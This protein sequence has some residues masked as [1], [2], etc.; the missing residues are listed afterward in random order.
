MLKSFASKILDIFA[1]KDWKPCLRNGEYVMRRRIRGRW[2]YR[3]PTAE[4]TD[5]MILWQAIK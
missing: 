3:N 2:E 5:E 1:S 4:E